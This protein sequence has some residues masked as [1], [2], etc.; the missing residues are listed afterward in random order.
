MLNTC[1][2]VVLTDCF[3]ESIPIKG[4]TCAIFDEFDVKFGD[5]TIIVPDAAFDSFKA[6]T[7]WAKF[8]LVK[9]SEAGIEGVEIDSNNAPAVYYNLQGVKVANPENGVFI[10]VQGGKV[11]KVLV[12]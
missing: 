11:S 9:A 10:K 2:L 12:K 7:K 8:N 6:N 1:F 3:K 5:I 4:F